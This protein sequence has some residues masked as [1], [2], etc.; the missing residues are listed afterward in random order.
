MWEGISPVFADV[1]SSSLTIDP[2]EIKKSLNQDISAIVPVHV[3]GNPCDVE[4]IKEISLENNL[5]VIYDAAHGFGVKYKGK[6]LLNYGDISIISFHATKLFHTI[7]GGAIV[8]NN[9]KLAHKIRL[10]SNFGLENH[11]NVCGIGINAKMNEFEAAMGLAVFE[12]I[13]EVLLS[14]KKIWK[15]YNELL[16]SELEFPEIRNGTD[17]NYSYVPVL[18]KS[19]RILLKAI[20]MLNYYN[21][22]PR[23]YFYPSLDTLDYVTKNIICPVSRDTS[24]RVL[25]LPTSYGIE[26]ETVEQVVNIIKKVIN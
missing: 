9:D 23:R 4:Q 13:S 15:L 2:V 18:F 14:R 12:R 21:I 10:M 3:Y 7:E 22:F 17:W 5:P 25:C 8:T 11:E 6:G 16:G 1:I 20:Q 26:Q 24:S 19:E